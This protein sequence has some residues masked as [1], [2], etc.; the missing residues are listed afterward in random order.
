MKKVQKGI[1][2]HGQEVTVYNKAKLHIEGSFC[3]VGDTVYPTVKF[4]MIGAPELG[5]PLTVKLIW[6]E[7]GVTV[8][9]FEETTFSAASSYFKL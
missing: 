9:E 3:T 2:Q 4:N 6:K 8:L 1:N 7:S 5:T